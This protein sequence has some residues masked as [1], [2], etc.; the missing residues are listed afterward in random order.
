MA[1]KYGFNVP[2]EE[3]IK[4]F[5]VPEPVAEAVTYASSSLK[6]AGK[7]PGYGAGFTLSAPPAPAPIQNVP[8]FPGT[9][10]VGAPAPVSG[11]D[12][13]YGTP[14]ILG[15]STFREDLTASTARLNRAV[16]GRY[17]LAPGGGDGTTLGRIAPPDVPTLKPYDLP[18]RGVSPVFEAPVYDE[19]K[20]SRYAQEELA[21]QK[22]TLS[23]AYQQLVAR[24]PTNPLARKTMRDALRGYGTALEYAA[25][26][27]KE[28]GRERYREEYGLEFETA[29]YGYQGA[30]RDF[31]ASYAASVALAQQQA[32]IENRN[33]MMQ[34]QADYT[35]YLRNP[36]G[37]QYKTSTL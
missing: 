32:D 6:A 25:S 33:L 3:N 30:T 15:K 4:S 7:E 16:L 28:T 11:A 5:K 9:K 1:V 8:I 14:S 36:T 27:A 37:K 17:A 24:S 13:F 19:T 31:E 21:P 29:R 26:G 12:T 23:E 35:E 10:A 2:E 22:R 20:V 34:Y 18:E